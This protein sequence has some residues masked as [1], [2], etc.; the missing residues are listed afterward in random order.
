[1]NVTVNL[2][3]LYDTGRALYNQIKRHVDGRICGTETFDVPIAFAKAVERWQETNPSELWEEQQKQAEKDALKARVEKDEKAA[4]ARLNW[5]ETQGLLPTPKNIGLVKQWVLVQGAGY[6]SAA[7][8]DSAIN[9]LRDQ[10][11]WAQPAAPVAS[12][13]PVAPVAPVPLPNGEIELPLDASEP[14]MRRASVAQLQDLDRRRNPNRKAPT[15]GF[16]VMPAEI[17]RKAIINAPVA[18]IKTWERR[19]G[20][21][22]ID[23]RL[24]GRG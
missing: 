1:M 16:E 23:A 24:Q 18:L 20:R 4:I 17:T 22:A 9:A 5:W 15:Y 12:A 8:I 11:E 3:H 6:L 7:N 13:A 10:L 21:D 19:F 2:A 14:E